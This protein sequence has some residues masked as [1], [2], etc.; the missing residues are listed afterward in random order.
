V[1]YCKDPV[2][3]AEEA[4]AQNDYLK[5]LNPGEYMGIQP[6][7]NDDYTKLAFIGTTERFLTHSG[8]YQLKSLDWPDGKPENAIDHHTEY[9]GDTD[10]FAGLY[11][12]N[13]TYLNCRFLKGSQVFYL[14]TSEFK[15]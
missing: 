7:F 5:V 3:K 10:E 6:R 15:G 11:G 14:F 9:P 1:L 4:D 8:N 2:F 13:I 12:Y